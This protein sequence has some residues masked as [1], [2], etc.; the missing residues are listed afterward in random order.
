MVPKLKLEKPSI[1]SALTHLI[2]NNSFIW[3][4]IAK[5]TV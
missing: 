3:N 4:F 1:L 2:V 5:H